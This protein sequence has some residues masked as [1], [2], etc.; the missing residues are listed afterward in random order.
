MDKGEIKIIMTKTIIT[1]TYR[2]TIKT[3]QP[4][5]LKVLEI[6]GVSLLVGAGLYFLTQGQSKFYKSQFNKTNEV[7]SL[8]RGL[9]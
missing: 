2:T 7:G 6:V 1:R 5:Y 8:E 9:E 4:T 3:P